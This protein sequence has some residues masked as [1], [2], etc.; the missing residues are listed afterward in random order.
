[1]ITIQQYKPFINSLDFDFLVKKSAK[2]IIEHGFSYDAFLVHVL[3][4]IKKTERAFIL[5]EDGKPVGYEFMLIKYRKAN[6]CFTYL[7]PEYRGRGLGSFL[8]EFSF[9]HFWDEY[10]E[11]SGPIKLKNTASIKSIEKIAKKLGLTTDKNYYLNQEG[12]KIEYT[13]LIK[14]PD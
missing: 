5:Y 4:E 7:L 8:R 12:E 10:D 6:T 1:M 3:P 13:R 9:M 14:R 11:I 2:E